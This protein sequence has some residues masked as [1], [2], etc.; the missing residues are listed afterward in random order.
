MEEM[1]PFEIQYDKFSNRNAMRCLDHIRSL[2][3]IPN[4]LHADTNERADA[5]FLQ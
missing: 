2:N 5:P 1:R 3:R 4:E